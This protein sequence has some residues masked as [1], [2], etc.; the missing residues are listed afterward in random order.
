MLMR[1]THTQMTIL[2]W[3]VPINSD[4]SLQELSDLMSMVG[5]LKEP[6]VSL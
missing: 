5:S 6:Q 2:D 3:Y 1:Y 4:T